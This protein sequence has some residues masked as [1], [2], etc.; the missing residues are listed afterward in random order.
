M[1]SVPVSAR[2]ATTAGEL[3]N[4]VGVMPL[5][6]PLTGDRAE[7]LAAV[8]RQRARLGVGAPRG[9]SGAATSMGFRTLAALGLFEPFVNRQRLVHTFV[10]NLRGPTEPILLA[11]GRV[12][13]VVPMAITPGNVTVSFDVLS[14]AGRLVVTVVSDP[15]RLP[16][17]ALLRDALRPS[18]MGSTSR[19]A[20]PP[21]RPSGP[22]AVTA[23]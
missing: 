4:R 10:T 21:H 1:V 18:W 17:H 5:A 13:R 23:S 2:S 3:G 16:E 14:L 20:D 11:G 22:A 7:R 8:V 6:V 9:S 15:T 12:T 19:E